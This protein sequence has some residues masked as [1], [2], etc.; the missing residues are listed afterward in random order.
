MSSHSNR[1]K[2]MEIIFETISNIINNTKHIWA[3]NTEDK[4]FVGKFEKIKKA[5]YSSK[6]GGNSLL[7][8]LVPSDLISYLNA[9]ESNG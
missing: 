1:R 3:N 9:Y 2:N 6:G 5:F 7:F 8:R 4:Q